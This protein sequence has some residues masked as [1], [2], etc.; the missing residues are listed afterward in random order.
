M[1]IYTYTWHDS[2]VRDMTHSLLAVFDVLLRVAFFGITCVRENT[3][4][5]T[6]T[7]DMAHLCV[8]S[9]IHIWHDSFIWDMTD[10]LLALFDVFRSVTFLCITCA[11]ENTY[12]YI[13]MCDMTH[14]CVTWLIYADMSHS[15]VTC[16]IW[17]RNIACILV[18]FISET[19]LRA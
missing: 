3:C 12:V 9:L 8:T 13:F 11:R 7:C 4:L 2:F 1:Y 15:H 16:L 10:S 6:C 14:L 5:Y 17:W 19:I 18:H